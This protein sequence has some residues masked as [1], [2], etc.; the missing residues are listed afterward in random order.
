ML[1]DE[2]C[3]KVMESAWGDGNY[4][5]FTRSAFDRSR[6]KAAIWNGDSQADFTGLQYSVASGIRAGL[7]GFSQ[8]G[9]DTGGTLRSSSSPTEE[10][11]RGGCTSAPS[12]PCT[13]S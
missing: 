9:S 13:K 12:H 6:S 5:S 2:I 4:Y 1:F 3:D 8:W 7:L 10:V 11:W